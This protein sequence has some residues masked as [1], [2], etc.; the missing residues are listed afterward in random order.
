MKFNELVTR[1][2][3]TARRSGRGIAAG[4]GKTAGRGTKGQGARKSS[5]KQG[6]AGGQTPLHMQLPKLRGFKS[7]K[8]AATA[9][10]TG[11]LNSVKGTL[12]DS[13][14][15]F[16]AGLIAHP[17]IAVKL[18]VKGEILTKKTVRVQA[19]S[20]T[21]KA[22]VEKAGGSI[23]IVDRLARQKISTK[24]DKKVAKQSV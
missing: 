19:A 15:L 11:Q 6:F 10:Y 17:H 23:E 24:K 8:T 2:A 16:E 5:T 4:H 1:K 20:S 3:K 12:I 21:A 13:N 9:I 7:K 14:T 18:I 22:A